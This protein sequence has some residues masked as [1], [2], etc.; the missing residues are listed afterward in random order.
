MDTSGL[1]KTDIADIKRAVDRYMNNIEMFKKVAETIHG[2]FASAE[3]L[4]PQVHSFKYRI[5]KPSHVMDKLFRKAKEARD[6]GKEPS[7]TSENI[8]AKL[9]DL[10]GVRILY[11]RPKQIDTILPITLQ[12]LKDYSCV[13]VRKPFAYTW[14]DEMRD[15]FKSKGIATKLSPEFY[16]SVHLVTKFNRAHFCRCEVQLRTLM[17]E[18]WGEVSHTINY[19]HK[20]GSVACQEQLKV[21]ARVASGSTRLVDSI[22]ASRDE[23]RVNQA[24]MKR[25]TVTKKTS[26]KAR[27]KARRNARR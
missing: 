11:L 17:E 4:R 14:D 12:I 24:R 7:I 19:P 20:T 6:K 22:F 15:R 10:A 16:T 25:R 27:K 13:I 5:K 18:V 8:F 26:K 9:G 2:Y 1:T 23:Y 3:Q 21:L